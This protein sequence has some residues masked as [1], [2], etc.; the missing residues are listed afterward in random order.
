MRSVCVCVCA[1]VASCASVSA[2]CAPTGSGSSRSTRRRRREWHQDRVAQTPPRREKKAREKGP[3]ARGIRFVSRTPPR[4]ERKR[5]RTTRAWHQDCVAH[6]RPP[7][8]EQTQNETNGPTP[9]RRR[10]AAGAPRSR[11]GRRDRARRGDGAPPL[12]RLA[13]AAAARALW[14]RNPRASGSRRPPPPRCGGRGW[15]AAPLCSDRAPPRE[16]CPKSRSKRHDFLLGEFGLTTDQRWDQR[17]ARG[18]VDG[19]GRHDMRAA[20]RTHTSSTDPLRFP[21]PGQALFPRR[22]LGPCAG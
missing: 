2:C 16:C 15:H 13:D 4:R 20:R 9:A 17:R 5:E 7:H 22:R 10:S 12:T 1:S 6:A 14:W 3:L 21:F 11:R 8:R 19:C 18:V